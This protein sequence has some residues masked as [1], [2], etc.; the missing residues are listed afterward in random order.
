M[1]LVKRVNF[2]K[3]IIIKGL[4]TAILLSCFIYLSHFSIEI[5]LLNSILGLAS[6]FMLLTIPRVS[7]VIAGFFTGI[8]W[9]YWIAFSFIYYELIYLIPFVTI[10]FGLI[11]AFLFF[12]IDFIKRPIFRAFAIFALTYIEPFGFNW[13]KLELLF[14]DSYFDTSKLSFALIIMSMFFL[15]R[16]LKYKALAIIPLLFAINYSEPVKI[17]EPNLKIYMA[18]LS[19]SQNIKWNQRN[20]LNIIDRNIDEINY[21]IDNGYDLVVLPETAFPLLLDK[22]EFLMDFLKKKSIKIDI[23]TGAMSSDEKGY[24]NSTFHFSNKKVKI[25]NKVVLVPFGE[26]IP[27]PKILTDLIN[28]IFY[29]SAQDYSK[30][31]K[32]TDFNIKGYNFRNAICYEA[33]TDE[34]FQNLNETKYI[35]A[36]SNNA[37]FMPSIE[38]TIQKLLMKYYAKKYNSIIYHT[39]NKSENLIIKP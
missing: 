1:F 9:F 34:I 7:L 37:W 39:V 15:T 12:L 28:K 23:I 19:T 25:A 33:T 29:D 38:P 13:F 21:A 2:N 24:Y 14:I 22:N 3:T 18:K 4:I 6:I 36:I 35:I 32:P 17:E 11:I 20:K 26:E 10:A 27:L 31:S 30:A 5:K 16:K 8:F